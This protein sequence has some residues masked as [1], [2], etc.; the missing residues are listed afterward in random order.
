ML[1]TFL[2]AYRYKITITIPWRLLY[3]VLTDLL[4][5]PLQS[6]FQGGHT[7]PTLS[8]SGKSLVIVCRGKEVLNLTRGTMRCQCENYRLGSRHAVEHLF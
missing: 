5:K 1:T 8:P 2:T 4:H 7:S 3:A 6:G